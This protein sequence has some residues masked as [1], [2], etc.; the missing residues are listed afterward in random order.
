MIHNIEDLKNR[1]LVESNTLKSLI[2]S[3][4]HETEPKRD[5]ILIHDFQMAN[6]ITL[7]SIVSNFLVDLKYAWEKIGFTQGITDSYFQIVSSID[8]ASDQARTLL[9]VDSD[10]T[11]RFKS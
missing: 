1:T 7:N 2:L 11:T 10:G 3:S 8:D 4:T 5:D 6:S 9:C